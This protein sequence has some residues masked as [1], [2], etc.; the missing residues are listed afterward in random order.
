MGKTRCLKIFRFHLRAFKGL[1]YNIFKCS[2]V[3]GFPMH[4]WALAEAI[5]S[6]V[7]QIAEK[8]GLKEVREVKIKVGELQQ[9]EK[10]ILEFALSELKRD[11]FKNA[12]FS[13]EIVKAE[14]QCRVCGQK[15]SF[16]LNELDAES[17]EAIHFVPETVHAYLKCPRCGSPDSEVLRGRGVWLESLGEIK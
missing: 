1:C 10:D 15:W 16:S 2:F 13:I 8:E 6:H 17:S 4:E 7:S 14:L 12:K 11:K 3:E 9:V 5:I